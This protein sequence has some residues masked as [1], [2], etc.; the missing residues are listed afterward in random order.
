MFSDATL[1][2][3]KIVPV[4][5]KVM[6]LAMVLPPRVMFVPVSA[7]EVNSLFPTAP[8]VPT[9]TVLAPAF[10]ISVRKLFVGAWIAAVEIAPPEE[11][12]VKSV[13]AESWIVPVLKLKDCP[14]EENVVSAPAFMLKLTEAVYDWALP[15]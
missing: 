13:P 1:P 12:R 4:G 2:P 15:L 5:V 6:V 14:L 10:T 11:E 8:M 3:I 9:W 7:A